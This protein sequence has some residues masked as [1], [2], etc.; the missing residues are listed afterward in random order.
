M[1]ATKSLSI[2]APVIG[3]IAA[4]SYTTVQ[5]TGNTWIDMGQFEQV[6]AVINAG[7]FA[8]NATLDATVQQATASNGTNAKVISGKSITQMTASGIAELTIKASDL[9]INN[10]FRY[11]QFSV[12]PATAA[13]VVGVVV[14]G[15]DV[16]TSP[17]T[18]VSNQ[19][20]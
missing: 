20:V 4:A 5:T 14:E 8:S 11:V 16:R 9:D 6:R 15:S 12:T 10:G 18:S 2:S 7:T 19:I 17:Q 3:K 1:A 13:V